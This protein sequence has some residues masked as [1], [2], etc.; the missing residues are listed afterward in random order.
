MHCIP[1]TLLAL[2]A[3]APAGAQEELPRERSLNLM[4]EAGHELRVRNYS[5]WRRDCTFGDPPQIAMRTP[6]QHGTVAV[7]PGVATVVEVRE[8]AAPNCQ[9]L[10]FPG[11]TVFYTS[12]P[13]FRGT[14]RF[15][16]DV[17]GLTTAHDTV[18][19]DVR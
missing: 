10:R 7:R 14:D 6:P 15:D 9:G 8:G 16:Y 3:A 5:S 4:A 11:T 13:G 17:V 19:V 1:V 2:L 12:V 18:T